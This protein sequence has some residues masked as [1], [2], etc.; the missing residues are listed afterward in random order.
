MRDEKTCAETTMRFGTIAGK[1]VIYRG[2][3]MDVDE[4]HYL[5]VEEYL[6]SL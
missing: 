1:Y 5:N 4:I 2:E 3:T 6:R